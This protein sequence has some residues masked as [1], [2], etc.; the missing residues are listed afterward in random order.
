[1]A[2]A[3]DYDRLRDE[4]ALAD[5]EQ[6]LI[7]LSV[8]PSA[9][10]GIVDFLGEAGINGTNVKLL[11]EKP[12]GFD[13]DTAE[14][15]L[16]RTAQYFTEEQIYRID[17]YAAKE[18][19]Q[20][21]IQL[22]ADAESHHHHWSN[23]S[24]AAVEIIAS[25]EIGVEDR[26]FFYEQTGALR[27]FL[28]GHL[29]QLLSLVTMNTSGQFNLEALPE[30]R[31]AALNAIEPAD[32]AKTVR[33][34][35]SG[36]GEAVENPGSLTETFVQMSLKSSDPRWQGVPLTLTT[37]KALDKKRSFVC[38]HYKD[39]T[40]EVFDEAQIFPLDE[41]KRDAYERVILEAIAG[42]KAIFTTGSEVIRAWEIVALVQEA[43]SMDNEPLTLYPER[44]T[45]TEVIER[46]A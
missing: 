33:A 9:A 23:E 8:P 20:R 42:N 2:E 37:G 26:A 28:Q 25:E 19:S 38:I 17:H 7:Y 11:F 18:L 41:R 32:P 12:F 35:Y 36:Y 6:A 45:V 34:Q 44:A 1:L 24:V 10:A 39:G 5:D 22:R 46:A 29:L 3:A 43:W 13:L 31:L 27:D 16:E 14:E 15:Y 4:L 30:R 40:E 21:L